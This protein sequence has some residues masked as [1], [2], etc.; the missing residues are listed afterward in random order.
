M[1]GANEPTDIF[2]A[3]CGQSK[4]RQ[5]PRHPLLCSSGAL[6]TGTWAWLS[7]ATGPSLTCSVITMSAALLAC[8]FYSNKKILLR[9]RLSGSA[10]EKNLRGQ[11]L[12]LSHTFQYKGL[13]LQYKKLYAWR[14]SEQIQ[15]IHLNP[16]HLKFIKLLYLKWNL[17]VIILFL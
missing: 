10:L 5:L 9:K 15:L 3:W 14:V 11:S 17:C 12:T 16:G 4:G 1:A 6:P 7:G 2:K 8:S 13:W